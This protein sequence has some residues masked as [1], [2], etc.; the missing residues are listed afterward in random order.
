MLRSLMTAVTG[1]RAHQTMLDVT[2]NNIANANTTGFKKDNTVFQDLM[3]QNSKLASAPADGRGGINPAQVGLGVTVG[4]IETIYTQGAASYTG[5]VS[6]MMI[7]GNGFFVFDNGTG[8]QLYTRAGATVRDAD[9]NLVQ[10]GTGYK[11]QGYQMEKDPINPSEYVRGSTIENVNIPLGKKLD[12]NATTEV[13]FQCNL[14][15]RS[16]AYLPYGFADLPYNAHCGYTGNP[17]G[18]AVIEMDGKS[19]HMSLNTNFQG[20]N[21]DENSYAKTD[22]LNVGEDYL[23]IKVGLSAD[24]LGT[25]SETTSTWLRLDMTGVSKST[26]KPVL[27]IDTKYAV[28]DSEDNVIGMK[29]P[30]TF[31]GADTEVITEYDEETGVF[32][33]RKAVEKTGEFYEEGNDTPTSGTYYVGGETLFEY[34]VL[35]NMNYASATLETKVDAATIDSSAS[36]AISTKT[37][38]VIM[39]FDETAKEAGS[40]LAG[41][42]SEL[43][44]WFDDQGD[45]PDGGVLA[46]VNAT[47]H[48]KVDGTFDYVEFDED[49][50]TALSTLGL[51]PY[52]NTVSDS[53]NISNGAN[54]RISTANGG[55]SLSV[56]QG[57]MVTTTD[58]SGNVTGQTTSTWATATTINQGG[59]HQTKQT[60]YDC[61][62][63]EYTLEVNFK[64][65]TE[66][67]WR[68]EAFLLDSEG[69]AISS[70]PTCDDG[71]TSTSTANTNL[72]PQPSSGEIEFCGCG[73]IC[74]VID[75][76]GSSLDAKIT[77]PFS[78]IGMPNQTI[79]LNMGGDGDKMYGV[80]Q[81][82]SETTTKAVYQNGY[83]M[84]ILDDYSI[85]TDG[86]ITGN[87]SNG[88]RIPLYRVAIATFANQQ[89]LEKVGESMFRATINSGN[90]NIDPAGLNGKGTILSQN[91]EMSN[92]DLTEE[93]T[94]MIIAQRGFQANTRVITTSDQILEEVVNLKR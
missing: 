70:N 68:W 18:T 3:Y 1:V 23:L 2:G 74:N 29:E 58:D 91:L 75:G 60:I 7:N 67:R 21:D 22:S 41:R 77:I 47:V 24:D 64:K 81:F 30:Y 84:G 9:N 85:G 50:K 56:Q 43:T 5:N 53:E 28:Y 82:A 89:G 11:L 51:V 35:S 62:G 93:F 34:N 37:Y 44:L 72:A 27:S 13:K 69:N 48:F 63:N 87:Y 36:H 32:K 38:S 76:S 15:S 92:V 94:H 88:Q 16:E 26:G 39:E 45:S 57:V 54:F 90:A 49:A 33:I 17:A 40:N 66:N 12:P 78:L 59:F 71:T 25:E 83:G 19:Y 73:P 65:V 42:S 86:T 80:T 10:S 20:D 61:N 14:D 8:S 4:A 46:K 79:S 31:P 52:D 6:D 55:S